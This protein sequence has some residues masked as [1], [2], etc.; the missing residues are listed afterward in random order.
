MRESSPTYEFGEAERVFLT[1]SHGEVHRCSV[2]LLEL[3]KVEVTKNRERPEDSDGDDSMCGGETASQRFE[4][5]RT[6]EQG[7]VSDPDEW[8]VVHYSPT[9]GDPS[10]NESAEGRQKF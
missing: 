9:A 4:R 6:S 8:A 3:Q 5:Y 1:N 7:E 2:R 10:E